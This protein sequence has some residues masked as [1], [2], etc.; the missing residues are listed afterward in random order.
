VDT[1]NPAQHTWHPGE[2][3][4]QARA[5]KAERLAVIGPRVVRDHM[6]QQHRDFFES[7]P[8][9]VYAVEDRL[10]RR[11]ASVLF[12]EPGFVRAATERE[13]R[14][15]AWGN[16]ADPA[17]QQLQSGAALG[18]LGIEF[19]SRRR[20]RMNG[21]VSDSQAGYLEVQCQQSFGNCPKYIH[22]RRARRNPAYGRFATLPV[23]SPDPATLG[24]IRRADT[25]FIASGFDDG[26]GGP[27]RG[28]D[29]SHRGGEPGF[30]AIDKQ[31]RLLVP[32]YAGN[33]FFC[34]LGN[35][36]NNPNAAL[37]FL[38]FEQGHLLQLQVRGEILHR[39]EHPALPG[40]EA[41][42]LRFSIDQGRWLI[43]ARPWL[44]QQLE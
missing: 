35:L 19:S 18:L 24:F 37:L 33:S 23:E 22:P 34:T 40:S 8:M 11:H 28:L 32:D 44:W 27:N 9:L 43:N 39:D 7:L 42:Y 12:G 3:Q 10:R 14:I 6:P 21:I 2:L 20:N 25:F 36:V 41:R 1:A 16:A 13:L 38:D 5:G 15:S 30:I 26:A 17:Q 29:V 31:H 4:L